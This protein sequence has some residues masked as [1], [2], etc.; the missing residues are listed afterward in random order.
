M[1]KGTVVKDKDGVT[2][3]I[4][5][6]HTTKVDQPLNLIG[7]FRSISCIYVE[8]YTIIVI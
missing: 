1:N 6:E 7:L 2:R 5:E 4:E 8:F 3:R